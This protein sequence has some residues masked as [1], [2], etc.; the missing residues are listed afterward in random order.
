MC[1]GALD[2]NKSWWSTQRCPT[3]PAAT[4][5]L[6]PPTPQRI[7]SAP[8]G[9][10]APRAGPSRGL[11]GQATAVPVVHLYAAACPTPGAHSRTVAGHGS[12]PTTGLRYPFRGPCPAITCFPLLWLSARSPPAGRPGFGFR[13]EPPLAPRRADLGTR[14][15][16]IAGHMVDASPTVVADVPLDV[17]AARCVSRRRTLI[18]G[19]TLQA[20]PPPPVPGCDELSAPN[21]L[22][23]RSR[24]RFL[25][26]IRPRVPPV[27]QR[28]ALGDQPRINILAVLAAHRDNAPV[29]IPVTLF[30]CHC[31]P[32]DPSGECP[33]CPTS[34]GPAF[35][36]G[37]CGATIKM[38][39]ARQSG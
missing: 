10:V 13:A 1:C 20:L 24:R 35:A 17:A 25:V 6:Q 19:G 11:R 5:S 7:P 37:K 22:A 30:A 39:L 21:P 18:P 3:Q 36:S 14:V 26:H 9:R 32:V 4:P 34:A 27:R 12:A 2:A 8:R 15:V 33:G 28:P 31:P 29:A 16:A 23:R 38:R